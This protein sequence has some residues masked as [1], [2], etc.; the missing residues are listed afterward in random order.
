MLISVNL[1]KNVV[2]CFVV[3][4]LPLILVR[5]RQENTLFHNRALQEIRLDVALSRGS[6]AIVVKDTNLIL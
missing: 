3:K 6:G 1:L 4:L 2:H 5:Q